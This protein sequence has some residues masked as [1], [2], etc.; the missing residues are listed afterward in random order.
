MTVAS[1]LNA[2]GRNV[3]SVAPDATVR[4]VL[5]ELYGHRIGAV[6][7]MRENRV[8]GLLSERDVVRALHATGTGV[9]DDP[10]SSIMVSPVITIAPDWSVAASMEL[11]TA[12][13]IRHLPVLVDDELVGMVSIGDLVKFRIEEAEREAQELKDY[14]RTA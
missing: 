5:A 13:R 10:V 7:V 9:L 2:K 1:I 6:L 4:D 8:V 3:V 14:I 12:R 11:M